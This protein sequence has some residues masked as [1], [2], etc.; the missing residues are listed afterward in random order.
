MTFLER[1]RKGLLIF[2]GAMGTMIQAHMRQ[3]EL[4]EMLNL[5][6]PEVITGVHR[7]YLDAGADVDIDA[8]AAE[9]PEEFF[10]VCSEYHFSAPAVLRAALPT[11]AAHLERFYGR[12]PFA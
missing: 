7:A 8:Y 3:G 12:S 5:S 4:P 6:M 2:D 9:A 1:V 10:A 11:V